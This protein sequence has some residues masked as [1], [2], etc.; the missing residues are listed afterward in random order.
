ME[1][2]EA[3]DK[4]KK[5]DA[6]WNHGRK[7]EG[8]IPHYTTGEVAKILGI[9]DSRRVARMIDEGTL[10][11][12]SINGKHG[13]SSRSYRVVSQQSLMRYIEEHGGMKARKWLLTEKTEEFEKV[14]E[15]KSEILAGFGGLIASIKRVVK[16]LDPVDEMTGASA[17]RS[18]IEVFRQLIELMDRHVRLRVLIAKHKARK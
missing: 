16:N 4:L 3:P 13:N 7:I 5:F 15:H 2:P 18:R 9:K 10:K 1:A 12:R 14:L 6:I 8:K 17:D 11:G